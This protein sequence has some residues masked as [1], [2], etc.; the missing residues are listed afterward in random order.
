MIKKRWVG[1]AVILSVTVGLSDAARSE[2]SVRPTP[3]EIKSFLT[4][5]T[6]LQTSTNG[7]K[8]KKKFLANGVLVNLG[9]KNQGL[10]SVDDQGVM[11]QEWEKQKCSTFTRKGNVFTSYRDGKK[12][13]TWRI[14]KE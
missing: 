2:D 1:F 10:W 13:A 9:S 11:C 5:G 8:R 7:K 3:K 4:S 6:V 14:I 12:L